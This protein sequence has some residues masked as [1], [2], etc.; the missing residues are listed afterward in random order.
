MSAR[1]THDHYGSV[2]VALHWV[3]AAAILVL[4]PS[5][6]LM[7]ELE[8]GAR[9]FAYR[10]H[11]ALGGVVLVLTLAR[12][13]WR[14]WDDK[15]DPLPGIDGLHKLAF[16]ANHVLLY[17]GLLGASV[18]GV[19]LSIQSGL[20]ESL[21]LGDG[22]IPANLWDFG[23]RMAHRVFTWSV[24]VLL[25]GHVGGVFLHQWTR[26]DTIARMGVRGVPTA[27]HEQLRR[28]S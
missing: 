22:S 3:S 19:A 6:Y 11:L 1:S 21:F 13:A 23:P 16:E 28:Q 15:P 25:L 5:G 26:S 14:W 12:I 20:A 10:A 17:L 4:L 27:S 9:T 7:A 8:G 18:S 2:A 24:A